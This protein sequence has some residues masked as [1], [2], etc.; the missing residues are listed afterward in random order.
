MPNASLEYIE[1]T[2]TQYI[3]TGYS[4]LNSAFSYDIKFKINEIVNDVS[5]LGENRYRSSLSILD[6]KLKLNEYDLGN[7]DTSI[8][9]I[10]YNR[11]TGAIVF[12]NNNY[13]MTSSISDT[14]YAPLQL[15]KRGG[16]SSAFSKINLYYFKL[17]NSDRS[18]L[19]MD[20]IP[21]NNNGTVCMFDLVSKK[22]I[23]NA[24][25]GNFVAGPVTSAGIHEQIDTADATATT[26]D[27]VTGK[28]AYVQGQKITGTYLGPVAEKDINFYDYD[29]TLVDSYTKTEFLALSAMPANP[30]HA[31][32]TA[33]GWNWTLSDAQSYLSYFNKLQIGQ[34]YTTASGK[35][36]ILIKL[37]AT[38]GLSFTFNM[39]G[40][41]NW[42]DGTTDSNTS[43]TYSDYGNYTITCEGTAISSTLIFGQASNRRNGSVLEA[44]IVNVASIN[45]NAF[46]YCDTLKNVVLSKSVTTLGNYIFESCRSLEAVVIPS[47]V[48]SI[49]SYF[50]QD[51]YN[52]KYILIPTSVTTLNQYAF[53]NCYSLK[54]VTLPTE[55]TTFQ[56][57]Y[58][59]QNCYGLELINFSPS[60][61]T[62]TTYCFG[63]CFAIKVLDCSNFSS[64]PTLGNYAIALNKQGKIIVP[65]SLYPSWII[66]SGWSGWSTYIVKASEA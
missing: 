20:L 50:C 65:D 23:Y 26:G 28:T 44:R 8:H 43:H 27:I 5:I 56:T 37:N 39:A 6:S 42:G 29:G 10:S 54:E 17:Y 15:F 34:S 18:S 51:N 66:A 63:S 1:S 52:L 32:L 59:F 38:T 3:D 48:S 25:T 49:P 14:D 31:G 16:S 4:F 41:K 55:T 62:F 57:G 22:Y 11:S 9:E 12:D 30:T 47:T 45:D 33:Q 13:T 60:I 36:E 19:L 24:G 46:Q 61:N 58:T 64:I 2:G 35:T 40:A 21:M 53:K 7:A